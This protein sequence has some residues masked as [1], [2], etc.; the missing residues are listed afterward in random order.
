MIN[1]TGHHQE[2]RGIASIKQWAMGG[3]QQNL[4]GNASGK[5]SA[6]LQSSC[7]N[8]TQRQSSSATQPNSPSRP[9]R[10]ML[11]DRRLKI[12]DGTVALNLVKCGITTQPANHVAFVERH[13]PT[14][15]KG[16]SLGQREEEK[17]RAGRTSS[18]QQPRGTSKEQTVGQETKAKAR[19]TPM[20]LE[21]VHMEGGA[22]C[23]S[24]CTFS[25]TIILEG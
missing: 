17:A 13:S 25:G 24:T 3:G 7:K 15:T 1:I 23:R 5:T 12:K 2:C 16:R 20:E 18:H 9:S 11:Q 22:I 21:K 8:P 19:E 10:Q 4:R 6:T 14:W